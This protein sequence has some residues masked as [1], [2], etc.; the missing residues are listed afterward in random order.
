LA[1]GPLLTGLLVMQLRLSGLLRA[2]ARAVARPIGRFR[3]AEDGATAIEFAIVAFPFFVLMFAIFE[4]ALVFMGQQTLETAV[5]SAARQIRTGEAQAQGFTASQFKNAICQQVELLFPC[6]AQL[7]FD[8]RIY[9]TFA[10]LNLSPP[11]DANGNF[12]PEPFTFDPGH[13]SDIVLVRAYYQWPTFANMFGFDLSNMAGNKHLLAA[14]AAF[15][16]EP[17]PW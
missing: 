10:S 1:E 6:A 14:A 15:R 3:K 11:I 5:A 17:F 7:Y 16:N 13:G 9:P 8:V 2:V 4:T 12:A